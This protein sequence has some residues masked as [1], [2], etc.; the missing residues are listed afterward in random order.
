MTKP[1][2]SADVPH[3]PGLPLRSAA[4]RR[5]AA[6]A[7]IA[8]AVIAIQVGATYASAGWH[9]GHAT[10]GVTTY[11]LLAI[12]GASLIARRRYPV[13]VLAVTLA[14]AIWPG[15]ARLR[16]RV[17]CPPIR[18]EE[19]APRNWHSARS[20]P[21]PAIRPSAL[22]VAAAGRCR[23]RWPGGVPR[24]SAGSGPELKPQTRAW[25]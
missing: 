7:A 16:R 11:L 1:D 13:G 4:A 19:L 22:M 3:Q 2:L 6:D 23:V 12:G 15:A 25:S 5:W 9:R 14:E 17:P 21:R 24:E 10:A 8:V 20:S 18:A